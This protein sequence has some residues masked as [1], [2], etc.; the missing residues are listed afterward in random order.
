MQ[1]DVFFV[2][3]QKIRQQFFQE[4]PYCIG[5]LGCE[6]N[7]S[8]I[9]LEDCIKFYKQLVC[10]QNCVLSV[11]TSLNE[12][13]IISLLTTICQC[14]PENNTFEGQE[15]TMDFNSVP[16]ASLNL[17]RE[18]SMVFQAYP[19]DGIAET[20]FYIGEFLE[21]LFNGLSSFFVE[22]VREKRGLA[23]TVGATR[24]LGIHKGMFCLFAGTQK[25]E[26]NTVEQ[27]MNKAIHRVLDKKITPEEFEICRTC[28]KVNH[29]LHLQT[30]GRK[31]FHAGYYR[32]LNLPLQ[33]W[34]LYED[35]IDSI[36]LETFFEC[37][38]NWLKNDKSCT[39]LITPKS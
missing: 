29:Q 19:V 20:H 33:Q 24:L 10:K 38:Q 8:Q 7:I 14:L 16:H 30:I 39:L 25:S 37:C 4:H 9:S 17:N 27:E 23:Y 34:I 2:G 36:S 11:T 5:Q 13:A 12:E 18:Q 15:D 35:K 32:L 21:E 3:F 22:E 26:V 28:L 31:A 6:N 1:D